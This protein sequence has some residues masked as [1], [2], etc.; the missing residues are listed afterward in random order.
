MADEC[1]APLFY[2]SAHATLVGDTA[3]TDGSL[4]GEGAQVRQ[5]CWRQ[6]RDAIDTQLNKVTHLLGE[7]EMS[8]KLGESGASDGGA[9]CN[10]SHIAIYCI[11]YLHRLRLPVPLEFLV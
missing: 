2:H 7:H 11:N 6:I 10:A 1:D 9:D 3:G 8:L 4:M 5:L